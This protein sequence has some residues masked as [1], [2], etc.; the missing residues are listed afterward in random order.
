MD[1]QEYHV[2]DIWKNVK[3]ITNSSL[4]TDVDQWPCYLTNWLYRLIVWLN[5]NVTK[6]LDRTYLLLTKVQYY[7]RVLL[8]TRK[9][10]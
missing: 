4:I 9:Y 10:L 7:G 2:M 6:L 8:R 5:L 1:S 3:G